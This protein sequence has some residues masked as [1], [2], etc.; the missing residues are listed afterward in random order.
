MSDLMEL[1]ETENE[2]PDETD[3]EEGMCQELLKLVPRYSV[4]DFVYESDD[5][6][7][8]EIIE[9]DESL[10]RMN[11]LEA[12]IHSNL[13]GKD[14]RNSTPQDCINQFLDEPL[15]DHIRQ[16][17]EAYARKKGNPAFTLT[18]PELRK[19]IG[20]MLV[21]MKMGVADRRRLWSK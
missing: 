1:D 13:C 12:S 2:T 11:E 20:V 3:N 16:Q 9:D 8:D 5:E 21:F 19:Y 6:D 18:E 15:L 7:Q 4:R 14:H 17:S 10:Q